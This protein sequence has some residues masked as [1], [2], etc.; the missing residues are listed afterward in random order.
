MK[1]YQIVTILLSI[2]V[3][4]PQVTYAECTKEEK[5]HFKSIEDE[6]KI[7]IF[8]KTTIC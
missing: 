3:L 1:K 6:Y 4:L 8:E 7:T 5:K 2:F